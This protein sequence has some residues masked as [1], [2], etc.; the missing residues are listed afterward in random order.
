[1]GRFDEAIAETERARNLDPLSLIIN[2]VAGVAYYFARRYEESIGTHRKTL[3]LDP[4][5][6]LANTWIVLTYVAK[7]M[8][9]SV[10]RTIRSVETSAVEHAYSLGYFGYAFG[11]CGQDEDALRMLDV[12]SELAKKRYVSPVHQANVLLGLDRKDEA[13]D[14]LEKA[15]EERNPMLVLTKAAP[16][17]DPLKTDPRH[18]ELLRKIGF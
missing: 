2:A 9:E 17:F 12:L 13:F 15:C 3:E 11:V 4:N 1:M 8:C 5:F 10:V 14:L 7:G 6:L 18:V 16:F